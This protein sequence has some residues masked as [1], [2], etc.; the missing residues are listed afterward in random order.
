MVLTQY[1]D[2]II[3]REDTF[4]ENEWEKSNDLRLKIVTLKARWLQEDRSWYGR[5]V[6]DE[7]NWT[8]AVKYTRLFY[9]AVYQLLKKDE[10]ETEDKKIEKDNKVIDDLKAAI[11]SEDRQSMINCFEAAV[12][13]Y[14]ASPELVEKAGLVGIFD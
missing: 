14:Y 13:M 7:K 5:P 3:G 6:S 4:T 10:K 8:D 2:K 9:N 12:L 1:L 11:N